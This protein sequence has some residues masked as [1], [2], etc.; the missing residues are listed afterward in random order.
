MV[1]TKIVFNLP[2]GHMMMK[3][4][5]HEKKVKNLSKNSVIYGT[6]PGVCIDI[7]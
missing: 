6:A 3:I 2:L 5:A 7:S 4:L 1:H